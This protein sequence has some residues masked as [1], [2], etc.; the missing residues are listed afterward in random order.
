MKG[1]KRGIWKIINAFISSKVF[2][3]NL[4]KICYKPEEGVFSPLL[5]SPFLFFADCCCCLF[6]YIP[7]AL[8]DIAEFTKIE[9][10]NSEGVET[11]LVMVPVPVGTVLAGR[12]KG[13]AL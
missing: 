7:P 8:G 1:L 10:V 3:V 4:I 2:S 11:A 13:I 12:R 5:V 9:L 6:T